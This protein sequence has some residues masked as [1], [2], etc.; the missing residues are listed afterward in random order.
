EAAVLQRPARRHG[1]GPVLRKQFRI[2]RHLRLAAERGLL[3]QH[4]LVLEPVVLEEEAPP[5]APPAAPPP[6]FPERRAV[7][8]IVPELLEPLQ[9]PL[10]RG[11]LCEVG[12]GEL[13]L[14]LD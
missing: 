2:E 3:V 11:D 12:G 7:L 4:R 8:R 9:G 13:V 6:P 1:D 10:P 5:P 14:L